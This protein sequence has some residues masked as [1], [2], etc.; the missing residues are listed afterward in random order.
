MII[1]FNLGL[2]LLAGGILGL[3]SGY[4]GSLM[5]PRRLTLVIDPLSHLAL[6]GVALAL[7][8]N[9]NVILFAFIFLLA[10][11]FL[12]WVLELE[13][14]LPLENIIAILFTVSLA[15]TLIFFEEHQLE[16]ALIGDISKL[17]LIDSLI[18]ILISLIILLLTIR[19]YHQLTLLA[20][21]EDLVLAEKIKIKQYQFI[22]LI[23]LSLLIALGVKFVGG[24]LIAGLIALP[25]ASAKNLS[26]SLL[27]Y[28][29]L[30]SLFGLLTVVGGLILFKLTTFPAGP[31]IIIV[32]FLFFGFSLTGKRL[33][34]KI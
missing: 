24:L 22:F 13:T 4:L 8:L 16:E 3:V 18:I 15:F 14:K 1:D 32:G 9:Q 5:L 21:S 2:I 11:S 6:P 30:S 34:L 12:I 19:I 31:L 33:N 23:C 17:S 20:I 10:A 29:L 28:K 26:N 7:I 27:S 25:S